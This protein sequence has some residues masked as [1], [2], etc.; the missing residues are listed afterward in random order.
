M[1]TTQEDVKDLFHAY[2]FERVPEELV[3][4]STVDNILI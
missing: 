4:R 2:W 1:T 3:R